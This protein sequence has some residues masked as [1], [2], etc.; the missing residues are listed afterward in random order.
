M[1]VLM[2]STGMH[3]LPAVNDDLSSK[4]YIKYIM[5]GFRSLHQT[6]TDEKKR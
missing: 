1:E 6:V 5:A 3:L 4:S 2:Y